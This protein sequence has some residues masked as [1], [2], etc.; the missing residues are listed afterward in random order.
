M[1]RCDTKTVVW[2][3]RRLPARLENLSAFIDGVSESAREKGVGEDIIGRIQLALEEALVNVFRHAYPESPGDVV[4]ELRREGRNRLSIEI[5]DWGTAFDLTG[6]RA[7]DLSLG[8]EE[9][10]VG[11][12]GIFLIRQMTDAMDQRRQGD[13]N[14]LTLEVRTD[15]TPAGDS[16]TDAG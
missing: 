13:S 4:V 7:P 14:I 11:G 10:K 5:T 2:F 8:V 15:G 6:A 12:L 9:R 16:E 3:C 1:S